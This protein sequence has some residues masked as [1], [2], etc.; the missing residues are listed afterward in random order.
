GHKADV[1]AQD[2]FGAT[3]LCEAVISG[4]LAGARAL[5]ARKADPNIP[6]R[7]G[8]T[9]LHAAATRGHEEI[10]ALLLQHKADPN[11]PGIR[12]GSP[13]ESATRYPRIMDRLIAKGA[14]INQQGAA[15]RTALHVA[16]FNGRPEAVALL[17]KRKADFRVKDNDGMTALMW[18]IKERR[19]EIAN[20]L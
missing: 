17:L 19:T 20:L 4:D 15:G 1:N 9:P 14:K 10:I 11:A 7:T 5:L 18:A 8:E 12:G 13:L 16:T 3:P 2:D 6:Q